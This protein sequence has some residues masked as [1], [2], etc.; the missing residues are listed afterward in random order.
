MSPEEQNE[1][2]RIY[3]EAFENLK[4]YGVPHTYTPRQLA[5]LYAVAS[6]CYHADNHG[7]PRIENE[8]FDDLCKWLSDHY[9]DCL[10]QGAD[11]LDREQL[12]CCSGN[13]TSIFVKPYHEIAEAFLGHPCQCR[14]CRQERAE[15]ALRLRKRPGRTP[16]VPAKRP[17]WTS[18]PRQRRETG[19]KRD[20]KKPGGT[21]L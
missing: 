2:K 21:R 14:T 5:S 20:K 4:R 8:V 11:K 18:A 10:A 16:S 15:A 17:R 13:D 7:K 6:I 19:R 1:A 12:D 3:S 9:E